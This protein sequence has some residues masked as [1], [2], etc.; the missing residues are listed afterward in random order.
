MLLAALRNAQGC[1]A[2]HDEGQRGQAHEHRRIGDGQQ[3]THRPRRKDPDHQDGHC[4]VHR[5][6]NR[7]PLH[8]AAVSAGNGHPARSD[9]L[10][11][12]RQGGD[13][14]QHAHEGAEGAEL[15]G[16]KDAGGDHRQA[17]GGPIADERGYPDEDQALGKR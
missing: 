3:L 13:D 5:Q 15:C 6:P 12:D 10:Q 11:C 7:L 8:F 4:D 1:G 17:V 14:D 16:I 2:Q 9:G